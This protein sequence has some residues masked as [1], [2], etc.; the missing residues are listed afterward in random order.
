MRSVR[1]IRGGFDHRR[2]S[3]VAVV[4]LTLPSDAV[5]HIIAWICS[6]HP[7]RCKGLGMAY[8]SYCS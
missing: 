8:D 7:F 6:M 3:L 2:T 4:S 5:V 1:K